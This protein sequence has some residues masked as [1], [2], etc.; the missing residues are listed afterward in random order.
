MSS[1]IRSEANFIIVFFIIPQAQTKIRATSPYPVEWRQTRNPIATKGFESHNYTAKDP[2]RM[3]ASGRNF[4]YRYRP[5]TMLSPPWW[6]S[7]IWRIEIHVHEHFITVDQ[8]MYCMLLSWEHTYKYICSIVEGTRL[9]SIINDYRNTCFQIAPLQSGHPKT[10]EYT[11][12]PDRRQARADR[13]P[14][15]R[16]KHL[17]VEF[18]W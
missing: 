9:S 3:Q 16:Y 4:L 1:S 7:S 6:K 2:W 5:L 13:T 11:R 8:S 17:N 15:T 18:M 12:S 10:L 14:D